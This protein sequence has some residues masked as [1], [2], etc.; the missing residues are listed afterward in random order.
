MSLW[1]VWGLMGSPLEP[2]G[3]SFWDPRGVIFGALGGHFWELFGPF[4]EPWGGGHWATFGAFGARKKLYTPQDIL[5]L[6]HFRGK[7]A[8]MDENWVPTWS[9]NGQQIGQQKQSKS[10]Y[11]F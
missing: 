9:Q 11:V 4:W 10:G 2:L 6:F 8:Q 3:A 5:W 1:C 7:V